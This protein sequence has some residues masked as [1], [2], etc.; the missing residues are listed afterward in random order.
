MAH[1]GLPEL[2]QQRYDENHRGRMIFTGQQ[3][4]RLYVLFHWYENFELTLYMYWI[5]HAVG[6]VTSPECAQD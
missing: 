1:G 5:T 4:P 3:V 2:L 6:S